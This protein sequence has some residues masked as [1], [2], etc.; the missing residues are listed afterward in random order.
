[1]KA[2][3]LALLV[4]AAS[5]LVAV[6]GAQGAAAKPRPCVDLELSFSPHVVHPG[7]LFEF[8][9][10]LANCSHKTRR[11]RVRIDS[12]G[13]CDFLPSSSTTYRLSPDTG[14]T[15]IGLAIVPS[16]RGRYRVVGKAI[17]RGRV[18]DRARA[19]FTVVAP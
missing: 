16:C 15:G 14:F 19:G 13:P 17:V 7:E 12:F 5:I 10:S 3:A 1:M 4:F 11:I 18:I 8:Q 2:S 9:E 6:A